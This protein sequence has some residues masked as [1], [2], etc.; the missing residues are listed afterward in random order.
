MDLRKLSP[1]ELDE[2]IS[3]ARKRQDALASQKIPKVRAKIEAILKAEGLTL[4]DV[5]SLKLPPGAAPAPAARKPKKAAAHVGA[6]AR[7]KVAPKYRNPAD[8][9]QTWAGRGAQPRWFREALAAGS[10]ADDLLIR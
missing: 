10:V 5:F 4:A 2:L 1:A 8:P 7:R 9:T 6:D 3:R